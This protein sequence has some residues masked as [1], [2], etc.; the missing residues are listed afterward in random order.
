[1]SWRPVLIWWLA[2]SAVGAAL[3][4]LPDTGPR[5]LE[6]SGAHGPGLLDTVGIGLLLVGSLGLWRHLWRGRAA[7][8]PLPPLWTFA[9]GLGVGLVTASVLG[10]FGAWWAVGAGLLLVVQLALFARTVRV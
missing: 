4:A 6:F 5:L 8:T 2:W 7:F 10:D 1:M 9:A 3:V